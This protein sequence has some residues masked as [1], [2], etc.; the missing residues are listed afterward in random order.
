[1][2]TNL[3]LDPRRGR[4]PP[5]VAMAG[6]RCGSDNLVIETTDG[7]IEFTEVEKNRFYSRRLD[8]TRLPYT[9]V[10]ARESTPGYIAP[11]SKRRL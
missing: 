7:A 6:N 1:M 5:H 2:R 4:A 10:A 8:Q 11:A 9:M 3:L